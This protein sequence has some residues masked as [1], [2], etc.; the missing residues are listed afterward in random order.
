MSA[1]QSSLRSSLAPLDRSGSVRSTKS[2]RTAMGVRFDLEKRYSTSSSSNDDGR[3]SLLSPET[4]RS[5][6]TPRSAGFR[7]PGTKFVAPFGTPRTKNRPISEATSDS[8]SPVYDAKDSDL[9]LDMDSSDD[10]IEAARPESFASQSTIGSMK[11]KGYRLNEEK[12]DARKAKKSAVGE[13]AGLPKRAAS[14]AVTTKP[15]QEDPV[16]GGQYMDGGTEGNWRKGHMRRPS[17]ISI[18]TR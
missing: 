14:I 5:N 18:D 1:L 9:I 6:S 15:R 8:S 4:N 16:L 12:D 10:E 13:R 17:S 11:E 3:E 7:I 2:T